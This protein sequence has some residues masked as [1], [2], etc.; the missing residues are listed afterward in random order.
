MKWKVCGLRDPNNIDEVL[1]LQ[2]DYIGFIF[3]VRSA[4]FAGSTLNAAYARNLSRVNKVGVF[5][6]EDEVF[7]K[8]HIDRYA[9]TTVQLHGQ[10]SPAF[11][12]AI[13]QAGVE[14][15]KVFSVKDKLDPDSL[16]P[17]EGVAD[18]FLFDSKV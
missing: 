4:R 18:Y 17:Y 16:K 15:V 5:V 2:P 11:T 6:N 3:Y 1:D 13:K 9:L 7:I 12:Q 14:V 8:D 10:E